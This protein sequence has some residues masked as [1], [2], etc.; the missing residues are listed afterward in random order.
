MLI[1]RKA[2]R[3]DAKAAWDI[4]NAAILDQCVNDYSIDLLQIW[5][6][7]ALLENFIV[8]VEK[9]FHVATY[10]GQVYFGI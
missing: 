8:D 6:N 2:K 4:R 3:E 1:V 7:G 9:Y 5:T 10:N